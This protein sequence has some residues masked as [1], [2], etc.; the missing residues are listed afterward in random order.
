MIVATIAN[1][2]MGSLHDLLGRRL[3]ICVGVFLAI[4][5]FTPLPYLK[6]IVPLYFCQMLFGVGIAAMQTSP[7][8]ADYAKQDQ[9]G[10]A[11]G[12]VSVGKYIG[13][14]VSVYIFVL[15]SGQWGF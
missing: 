9:R 15:F 10:I 2:T 12:I 5:A 1:F 6:T 7:L 3:T 8:V 14:C 13:V 4:A 11:T